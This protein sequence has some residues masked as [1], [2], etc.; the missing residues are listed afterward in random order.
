MN[1]SAKIGTSGVNVNPIVSTNL[2]TVIK[3]MKAGEFNTTLKISKISIPI[4]NTNSAKNTRCSAWVLLGSLEKAWTATS[5]S[6]R[7]MKRFIWIT[8]MVSIVH[9]S[10]FSSGPTNRHTIYLRWRFCSSALSVP[11][12]DDYI[13]LLGRLYY[14][15]RLFISITTQFHLPILEIPH[16]VF[17]QTCILKGDKWQ[18]SQRYWHTEDS[19]KQKREVVPW[20]F[21]FSLRMAWLPRRNNR[22]RYSHEWVLYWSKNAFLSPSLMLKLD[23]HLEHAVPGMSSPQT[24]DVIFWEV[25]GCKCF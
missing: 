6:N 24:L 19:S 1:S 10:P 9:P 7:T 16:S 2:C 8:S 22:S 18:R 23:F 12:R 17:R 14:P 20:E 11:F 4:V 25:L 13:I 5:D 21:T 3:P 15:H